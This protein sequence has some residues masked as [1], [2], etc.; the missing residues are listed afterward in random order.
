MSFANCDTWLGAPREP[1]SLSE[2]A[3]AEQNLALMLFT[4]RLLRVRFA[5]LISPA[6]GCLE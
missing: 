4:M 1:P 2:L 3:I 6:F 5:S